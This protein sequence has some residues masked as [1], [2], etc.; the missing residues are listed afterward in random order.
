MH[1]NSIMVRASGLPIA[2]VT[3]MI[4]VLLQGCSTPLVDVKVNVCGT[5][6]SKDSS[7]QPDG[8][9]GCNSKPHGGASAAGFYDD[10][11]RAWIPA[12][13]PLTCQS[14]TV[15]KAIPGQCAGISCVGHYNADGVA[16]ACKCGCQP[17][18]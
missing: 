8:V 5:T 4:L 1:H 16:R 14:G 6:S 9:G 15:C 3:F 12:G 18:I 13:S 2:I 7:D 10:I 17:T 11:T